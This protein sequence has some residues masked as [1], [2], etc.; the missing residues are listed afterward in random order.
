M[1]KNRQSSQ[2][3]L[4]PR[5]RIPAL[6]QLLCLTAGYAIGMSQAWAASPVTQ[7]EYDAN[8]NRTK[9]TD[10]LGHATVSSYDALNRLVKVTDPA[11][12]QTQYG[13]DALDHLIQVTDPRSL[14]T[15]YAY[16][17]LNNLNQQVSPDTGTT[18]NTFD[19]AG[20]LL[21]KIDAKGQT[22]TYTYDAL[23]RVTS[24]TYTGGGNTT[25]IQITY[26]YDQGTNGLGRLTGLTDPTGSIA[27]AYDSHGRVVTEIRTLNGATSAAYTTT[28]TYD[29]A[30]RLMHIVYPSGRTV[31]LTR[32]SAG[33][34]S[35]V[36]TT[37]DG[38]TQLLANNIAYF[39]FGGV[40][41]LT[42]GNGSTYTRQFDQDGRISSYTLGGQTY[43]LGY[44][45]AS[46]LSFTSD[47]LN[48]TNTK[49]YGYDLLDRLIQYTAPAE[50]Q[51]YGYDAD[52][53]RT[54]LTLGGNSYGYG[55]PTTSNRLAG[56]TGPNPAKSYSYDANGSPTTDGVNQYAYDT[57][58]RLVQAV[59]S[60][61]TAAYA[62]NALG[63]R[64]S[65]SLQ[66][67]SATITTLYHYDLQGHLIA[68]S[69]AQGHVQQETVYLGDIP[70]AVMK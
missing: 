54:A 53:N 63:Q 18:N 64:I 51:G 1:T 8:G 20:N 67:N 40:Q 44:D 55:Y 3:Q 46:R 42:F 66:T 61:G 25:P 60:T 48:P 4:Q 31:D 21:T 27:Y 37:R 9:V 6:C 22:A 59:T 19:A 50:S 58:G 41:S 34:V 28:Y 68:E 45:A 16:D 39:P 56:T 52:G 33:R 32:D 57:R 36:S 47:A 26:Q 11:S 23:N 7:Y 30:G 12:G 38:V 29:S 14:V 24:I 17:G 62:I 49:N 65:K 43:A 10:G 15:S 69:D 13:Y 2:G 35:Q 5:R 70:L